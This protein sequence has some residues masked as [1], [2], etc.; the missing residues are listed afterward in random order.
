[1]EALTPTEI[2]IAATSD[3]VIEQQASTK[4]ISCYSE[5][6]NLKFQVNIQNEAVQ[7]QQR[8]FI[9]TVHDLGHDCN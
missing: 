1:M 4:T 5:K 2:T 7:A 9:L 3:A 6:L 8:C